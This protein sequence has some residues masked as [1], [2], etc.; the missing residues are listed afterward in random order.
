MRSGPINDQDGVWAEGDLG[1][2]Q[3]QLLGYPMGIDPRHD[4]SGNFSFSK[5]VVVRLCNAPELC[6][7]QLLRMAGQAKAL[8]EP[9]TGHEAK[10]RYRIS[11]A[12]QLT[13]V[14]RTD[15]PVSGD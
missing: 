5:P 2:D 7:A 13:N 3:L 1:T 6:A 8:I 9:S 10:E 11:L 14:A 15:A 4:Q 12:E